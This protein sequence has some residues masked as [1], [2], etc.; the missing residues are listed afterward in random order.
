MANVGKIVISSG[1]GELGL[2]ISGG[3]WHQNKRM[4]VELTEL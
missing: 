3:K 2:D 1:N 4:T